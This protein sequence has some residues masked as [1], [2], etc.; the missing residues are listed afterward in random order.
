MVRNQ[1]K[2]WLREAIRA[3]R[4]Q[5]DAVD[6]VFIAK[7]AAARAGWTDLRREVVEHLSAIR[8]AS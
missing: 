4:A 6:V 3:E 2:R 1:V 7:P 5:L 8:G